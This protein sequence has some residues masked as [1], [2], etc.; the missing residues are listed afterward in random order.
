MIFSFGFK[1][2]KTHYFLSK[3][4]KKKKNKKRE[5]GT[6][7][8][9]RIL[10]S[11]DRLTDHGG[12]RQQGGLPNG[13]FKEPPFFF[14]FV[15][16][17]ESK[18]SNVYQFWTGHDIEPVQLKDRKS[19]FPLGHHLGAVGGS[20]TCFLAVHTYKTQYWDVEMKQIVTKFKRIPLNSCFSKLIL[21]NRN[22]LQKKK[23]N[24]KFYKRILR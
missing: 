4:T 12:V 16:K 2:K 19:A 11:Q 21:A 15:M 3:T 20:G 18:L 23:K 22:E 13:S 8:T 17:L 5:K 7:T 6:P 10:L 9:Q 1:K 14:F 24:P